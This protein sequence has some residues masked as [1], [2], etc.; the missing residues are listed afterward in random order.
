MFLIRVGILA[1][2]FGVQGH[3]LAAEESDV[4]RIAIESSVVSSTTLPHF[5]YDPITTPPASG[6][7]SPSAPMMVTE[8]PSSVMPTQPADPT[9]SATPTNG[10]KPVYRVDICNT[11][12]KCAEV[13][14]VPKECRLLRTP[15]D[16]EI[17]SV[18]VHYPAQCAF[19]ATTNC[20]T[21]GNLAGPEPG[22][23][24]KLD[25]NG[26]DVPGGNTSISDVRAQMPWKMTSMIC[27]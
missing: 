19:T 25:V 1:M 12:N 26:G 16:A 2:I 21:Y 8:T 18:T 22:L 17:L 6:L 9:Q 11:E 10:T 13:E 20:S 24:N 23:F 5:T 14:V 27:F 3:P 15:L 7:T 4:V